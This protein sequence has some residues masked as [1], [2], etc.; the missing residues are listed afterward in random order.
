MT[1]I[2]THAHLQD[3]QFSEDIDQ[4]LTN[5]IASGVDRIILPGTDLADSRSAVALVRNYPGILRCAA[6]IHPHQAAQTTQ[7]D[8]DLLFELIRDHGRKEI[9]AVG[10][11]GLDYHYD[12]APRP[13]QKA[14]LEQMLDM[15]YELDLPL[16]MHDRESTADSLEI[17][18][19]QA[20]R[21]RLRSVPGVFHCFSGSVETARILLDM[22]FYLGFDGPVTFKNARKSHEVIRHCPLDRLL[23][24]TDSPYLAPVPFR[25]KR[26][27][28]ARVALVGEKIAEIK[29]LE[30][31]DAAQITTENAI[32]FFGLTVPEQN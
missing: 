20:A 5:A 17:L 4:V 3:E 13:V 29:A 15:A 1:W 23:V 18:R 11:V 28:P 10:E 24:E 31:A 2:D 9:V 25:G 19:R 22:G 26:N 21:G 8:L 27:E 7:S 12:F 30:L 16:V 6:G 32:S 14:L